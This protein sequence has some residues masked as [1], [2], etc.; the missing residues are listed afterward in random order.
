MTEAVAGIAAGAGASAAQPIA[1]ARAGYNVGV[2]YLRGTAILLVIVG[3]SFL[4]YYPGPFPFPDHVRRMAYPV[5]DPHRFKGARTFNG[6]DDIYLMALIFFLSGLFVLSSLRRKGAAGYLRDRLL[7]LGLPFLA[8]A[9]LASGL[10][11]YASYLQSHPT[12]ASI[13]DYF[14]TWQTPLHWMSGAAWFISFLLLCDLVL[15]TVQAGAPKWLDQLSRLCAGSANSLRF[16]A[17]VVALSAL[18]YLPL[19]VAFGAYDWFNIGPFWVQKSRVLLYGVYFALGVGVGGAGLK[20]SLVA[21]GSELGRRWLL[22]VAAAVVVFLIAGNVQLF[23]VNKHLLDQP[24]W[25]LGVGA[26]WI[27]SCATSA[28]AVTALFVRFSKPSRIL[29]SLS[30]NSYGMYLT[31]YP[32]VTWTQFALLGSTLPPITKALCVILVAASGS[33]ALTWLLRRIPIV[34]RVI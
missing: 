3:H 25:R 15:T 12:G 30:A 18:A 2:G 19:V 8:S 20:T 33:W 24:L 32:M 10:A 4:G 16:Y 22:W 34:A 11:Y 7:R 23:S 17:L 26:G 31:H 6:F 29:D 9:Y 13:A 5:L 1:A 21:P 14:A 28:F 27:I